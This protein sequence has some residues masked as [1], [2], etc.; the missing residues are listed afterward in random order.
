MIQKHVDG[1]YSVQTNLD[2]RV[3]KNTCDQMYEAI[4]EHFTSDKNDYSGQSTLT[5]KLFTKYNLLLY[6]LPGLH[7][8]YFTI[9]D[10]FHSCL[11][12]YH[13]GKNGR[14]YVMQCWLNY[15][16]KGDYINWHSHA[17]FDSGNWHGFLCVDTEP[18]SHTSYIWPN[19]EIRKGLVV[20]IK[21]ED[22]LMVMGLSNG[23]KHKSSEWQHNNRPRITI[24]FDINPIES[25]DKEITNQYAGKYLHA[26]KDS[27]LF[28]NHW[29]PI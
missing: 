25:I 15:Y 13:E 4:K 10:V 11:T 24:A 14:K 21:S 12:D 3:L 18:D 16:K 22:G 1:L 20:D 9:S 26:M 2:I 17:D 19:D 6:P 28:V 27:S 29:I 23:D 7:D 8:L 5:T